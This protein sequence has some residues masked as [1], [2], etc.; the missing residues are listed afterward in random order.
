M[1]IDIARI[2]DL[3]GV[4][5]VHDVVRVGATATHRAVE[6]DDGVRTT[7]PLVAE[8]LRHV[9]HV[10]IRNAGTVGG[11][12][13]HADPAAEW[14]AI[15]L[16]LD[17]RVHV[18]GPSGA[19]VAPLDGFFRDWMQPDLA[20]GEIVTAVELTIP[21]PGHGWSFHE[22][23]RRHGDFALA[24]A[25]V[26]IAEERGILTH[27]RIGLLGA[28]LTPQRARNTEDALMGRPVD[29]DHTEAVAG[30]L[31][32]DVNPLDD[33]HASADDKRH[34]ATVLTQRALGQA[35]DRIGGRT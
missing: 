16:A 12:I 19:R 6:L 27:V 34:L 17:G 14:P 22:V 30:G 20:V 4:S 9:G 11:S 13:A 31:V 15:A 5:L 32:P 18:S 21:P 33:Q 23:A 1:L 10:A 2:P 3:N 29:A 24:G 26:V 28:G 7:I 8:G 25:A 35:L